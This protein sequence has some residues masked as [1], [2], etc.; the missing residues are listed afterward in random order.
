M[1]EDYEEIFNSPGGR[2]VS[3]LE[4]M[5]VSNL[6][7]HPSKQL[8][9]DYGTGTGR[10]ARHLLKLN[11]EVVGIDISSD[12]LRLAM[13]KAKKEFEG[14]TKNYHIVMADGHHLPFRAMT[15]DAIFS[16]RTLKYLRSPNLGFYEIA[17]VIKSRGICV[18]E[19]SNIFGYEVL[20]LVFL[21]L[22][23]I[24]HYAQNM[25]SNYRLFNIFEIE[26]ILETL[27][28][29]VISKKG[30]HKI[31]TIFFIKCKRFTTLKILL[32]TESILQKIFP[33]FFFSRGILTKSMRLSGN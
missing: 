11:N 23:G 18:L 6:L 31:P 21:K 28:L 25:G 26:K 2:I 3:L 20:W 32:Y 4:I 17:R 5:E 14:K 30:L 7:E 13:E 24:K 33:F 29:T 12:R 19:L 10:L 22:F 8:I 27:N 1:L 9:L 16:I 15:F